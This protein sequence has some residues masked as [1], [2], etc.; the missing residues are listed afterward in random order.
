MT[1]CER[2]DR[3]VTPWQEE[4]DPAPG[5]C[6]GPGACDFDPVDW[7]ARAL[8]AEADLADV[9]DVIADPFDGPI[10]A[11]NG[12]P[13]GNLALSINA[14]VTASILMVS[15]ARLSA[16]FAA[17]CCVPECVCHESWTSRGRHSTECAKWI[18]DDIAELAK[19]ASRDE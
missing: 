19:E 10:V 12:T 7:R 2:C 3:P 4:R 1:R 14:M 5:E 6:W 16:L 18:A 17:W 13:A 11:G 9:R 8:A 15:E